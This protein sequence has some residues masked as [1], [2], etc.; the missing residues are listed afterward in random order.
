MKLTISIITLAVATS[1]AAFAGGHQGN[2]ANAKAM[3]ANIKA[4]GGNIAPLVGGQG[5]YDQGK[6]Q[7]GWGNAGSHLTGNGTVDAILGTEIR[8]E[9]GQVS[10]SGN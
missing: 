3:V 6:G 7:R 10:K 1:S 4:Y 5:V 9:G 8:T 2:S